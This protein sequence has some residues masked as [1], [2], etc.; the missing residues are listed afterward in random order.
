M[1]LL[2]GGPTGTPYELPFGIYCDQLA[3]F[4]LLSE[5]ELYQGIALAGF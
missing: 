2:P 1:R 5:A 4:V 3:D